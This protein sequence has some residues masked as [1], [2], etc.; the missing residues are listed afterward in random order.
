MSELCLEVG[1][2]NVVTVRLD[3]NTAHGRDMA[4]QPSLYLPLLV[5]AS[6]SR[7]TERRAIHIGAVRG[8]AIKLRCPF[9]VPSRTA[10]HLW[11]D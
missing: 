10:V 6:P 1:G 7:A 5:A 8:K 9:Q 2:R 4:G 11:A 3:P